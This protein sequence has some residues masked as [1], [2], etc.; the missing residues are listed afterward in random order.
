MVLRDY[1]TPTLSLYRF[2]AQT[3]PTGWSIKPGVVP[4]TIFPVD[5][6]RSPRGLRVPKDERLARGSLAKC[7]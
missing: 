6:K 5:S 3:Y 2:K 1:V 7:L 4:K